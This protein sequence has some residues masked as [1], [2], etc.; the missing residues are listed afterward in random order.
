M[1][2]ATVLLGRN[3]LAFIE[4]MLRSAR[5]SINCPGVHTLTVCFLRQCQRRPEQDCRRLE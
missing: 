5:Q 2:G 4:L 3:A 1:T